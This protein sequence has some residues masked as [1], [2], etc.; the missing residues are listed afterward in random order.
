VLTLSPMNEANFERST[1]SAV[2]RLSQIPEA[3][4]LIFCQACW[5]QPPL[6]E[7]TEAAAAGIQ[8]SRSHQI[9]M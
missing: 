2:I 9:K 8:E 1:H 6:L 7:H 3:S 4:S 5:V